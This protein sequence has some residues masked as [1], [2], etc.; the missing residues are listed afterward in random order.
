[1][2][3]IS[4]SKANSAVSLAEASKTAATVADSATKIYRSIKALRQ[5]RFADFTK[6]LGITKGSYERK[7]YKA[8]TKKGSNDSFYG[9][10]SNLSDREKADHWKRKEKK[11]Y[12]GFYRAKTDSNI[13]QWAADTWLEYSYGWKPLIQDVY[14]H[15]E[16]LAN[17][18]EKNS[19]VIRF[20][21]GK[22]ETSGKFFWSS[23]PPTNVWDFA[24]VTSDQRFC[25]VGV[26]YRIPSNGALNTANVFGLNNPA[27]VAWELVPF[28]FVADW[29]IPIGQ[30]LE[31]LTAFVGLGFYD[32]F[33]ST[34][35]VKVVTG[36]FVSTG[37]NVLSGG[38]N[39]QG[40]G[41]GKAQKEYVEIHRR[42]LID[43]PSV[44]FPQFKDPRSLAH[45]ASAIA[46]L[47][48]LF[49]NG[50][51]TMPKRFR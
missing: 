4:Q 12:N 43:F 19:N 49:L 13:P 41:G 16:A 33:V 51:S 47:K 3:R 28:S 35:D 42:K 44:P 9:K 17:V 24:R 6:E 2:S 32:G 15:A 30:A 34:R 46:L 1:M 31:N 38:Y 29:F 36:T 7:S 5:G 11:F 45:G 8:G 50:D 26:Y 14:D 18:I 27:V 48:S 25:R 22:A 23:K 10:F 39:Q 37:R 21:S 40:V 20:A